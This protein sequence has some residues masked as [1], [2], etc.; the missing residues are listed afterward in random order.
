M[1]QQSRC[2]CNFVSG[3]VRGIGEEYTS[4]IYVSSNR[5]L[6]AIKR[7]EDTTDPEDARSHNFD[8]FK[9]LNTLEF[10]EK[11]HSLERGKNEEYVATI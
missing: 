9:G 5:C 3:F 8:I 1:K 11:G 4:E 6:A 7:K 10:F 2:G